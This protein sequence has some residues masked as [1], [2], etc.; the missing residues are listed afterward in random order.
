[1]DQDPVTP[2]PSDID[3]GKSGLFKNINAVIAGLT[4]LA[5]ALGGLAA[6]TKGVLWDK[7]KPTE[8]AAAAPAAAAEPVQAADQAAA[9]SEPEQGDPTVY[10]GDGIRLEWVDDEWLLTGTDG[11]FHY[12]ETYSPDERRYLAYDK[13]NDAYLRW[14]IQG[15]MAE[16]G[17]SDKQTWTNYKELL[18]AEA[19]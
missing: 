1:M 3:D 18:P 15:G 4:G 2:P 19:E 8:T 12:E 10:E 5:V 7:D 9:N 13:A 14:P 16:E 17:T 11:T 6:A